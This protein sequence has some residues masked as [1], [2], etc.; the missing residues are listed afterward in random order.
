M[1]GLARP[2]VVWLV[3][4][5]LAGGAVIYVDADACPV[6][7]QIYRAAARYRQPVT[8]VANG[9]LRL[10]STGAVLIQVG[11]DPNAAD[12][13]IAERAGPGDL[14]ITADLPLA[15]RAL[16]AGALAIDFR[17]GEFTPSAIGEALAARDLHRFL[18]EMGELTGGP[19]AFSARDRGRFASKL[20]AVLNRLARRA[21][22]A[23][24]PP[25]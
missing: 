16:D 6:K 8:L 4:T 19:A 2:V 24:E 22:T 23:G 15:A 17:G 14:V 1:I 21:A 13:W 5:G 10:P 7:E 11:P 25:R 3:A 12:D 18:R 9:G 20:D